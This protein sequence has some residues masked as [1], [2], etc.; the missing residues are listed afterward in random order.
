VHSS[1]VQSIRRIT[2]GSGQTRLLWRHAVESVREVVNCNKLNKV[3][4]VPCFSYAAPTALDIRQEVEQI[5]A[6]VFYST[7]LNVFLFLPRISR[8]INVLYIF[9]TFFTSMLSPP[10]LHADSSQV[11]HTDISTSMRNRNWGRTVSMTH[12][13]RFCR[14]SCES[15]TTASMT[16]VSTV[17]LSV[18]PARRCQSHWCY[19][20]L[21][22]YHGAN[23]CRAMQSTGTL[24]P[25]ST[26][27]LLCLH[28]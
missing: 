3:L 11:A 4:S 9:R 21:F 16:T 10:H 13:P 26:I 25:R 28:L 8:F 1:S 7:F 14:E 18:C 5:R 17:C 27:W 12:Q 6:N 20:S 23:D 24:L 2:L 22:G 15:N 19:R